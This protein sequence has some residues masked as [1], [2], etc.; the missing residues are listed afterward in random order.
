MNRKI[1]YF[2]QIFIKSFNTNLKT[3]IMN[4]EN[5]FN[6]IDSLHFELVAYDCFGKRCSF[7]SG[8]FQNR[9]VA[10]FDVF[11]DCHSIN[12]INEM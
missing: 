1:V 12:N 7:I 3:K 2:I 11:T 6:E 5:L 9:H 4:L 10:K 8:C